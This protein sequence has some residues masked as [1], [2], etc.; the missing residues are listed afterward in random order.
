MKRLASLL[1]FGVLVFSGFCFWP[2]S[3]AEASHFRGGTLSYRVVS[4]R[5]VE[6]TMEAYIRAN[7]SGGNGTFRFGDGKTFNMR[8]TFT[9]APDGQSL[10][11]W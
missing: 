2:S 4:G 3:K 5:T 9:R 8:P 11:R 10:M 6:F 1:L 7:T